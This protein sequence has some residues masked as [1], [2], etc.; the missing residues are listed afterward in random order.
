MN[1]DE[2]PVFEPLTK[3]QWT[4]GHKLRKNALAQATR[5][6]NP[7]CARKLQFSK[8]QIAQRISE[9]A[10]NGKTLRSYKCSNCRLYHLTSKV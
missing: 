6:R 1:D 4:H 7:V 2:L 8:N 9:A 5:S 10:R 3:H